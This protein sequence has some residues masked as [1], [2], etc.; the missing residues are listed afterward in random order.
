MLRER[1]PCHQRAPF[2]KDIR[3]EGGY[4]V[5]PLTDTAPFLQERGFSLTFLGPRA[6]RERGSRVEDHGV[7]FRGNC[8]GLGSVAERR[9]WVPWGCWGRAGQRLAKRW[10]EREGLV[11]I[12]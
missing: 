9:V 8:F 3:Y 2:E 5:F 10:C 12:Y 4:L 11:D 1:Y 7:G 6:E